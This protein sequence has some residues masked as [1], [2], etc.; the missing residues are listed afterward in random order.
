MTIGHRGPFTRVVRFLHL[1][2]Y[3][4]SPECRQDINKSREH[5]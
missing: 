3:G 2:L 4:D 5:V 1:H